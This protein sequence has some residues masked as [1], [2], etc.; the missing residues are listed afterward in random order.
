MGSVRTQLAMT[1]I[2]VSALV[3]IFLGVLLSFEIERYY[4]DRLLAGLRTES[5]VIASL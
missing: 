4:F 3:I 5:D 2:A 1:F